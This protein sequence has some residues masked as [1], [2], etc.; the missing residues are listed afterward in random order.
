MIDSGVKMSDASTKCY[1]WDQ[2]AVSYAPVS[3]QRADGAIAI[4][5]EVTA[6]NKIVSVHLHLRPPSVFQ[7]LTQ[8]P[9]TTQSPTPH[10]CANVMNAKPLLSPVTRSTAR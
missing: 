10:L 8:S 2:H 6:S 4:F 9:P 7:C 5:P 3:V 1:Q